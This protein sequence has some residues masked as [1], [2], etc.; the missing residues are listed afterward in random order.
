MAIPSSARRST[1]YNEFGSNSRDGISTSTRPLKAMYNKIFGNSG[2]NFRRKNFSGLGQP[3]GSSM[4]PDDLGTTYITARLSISDR[5][6]SECSFYFLWWQG[7]GSEPSSPNSTSIETATNNTTYSRPI[8][9]LSEN[10]NYSYRGVL[11]N[12]FND[13]SLDH[14][15]LSIIQT[16]TEEEPAVPPPTPTL[17]SVEYIFSPTTGTYQ[18]KCYWSNGSNPDSYEFRYRA[19]IA[20]GGSGDFGGTITSIIND[21]EGLATFHS[22]ASSLPPGGYE[23]QIRAVNDGLY[24]DYSAWVGE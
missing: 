11:F 14:N 22:G 19:V 16:S 13:H 23:L 3:T 17:N 1:I 12:N 20:G 7:H 10:T 21:S 5:G 8:I 24:S 2:N 4:S 9:G 15:K 6:M 18:Y